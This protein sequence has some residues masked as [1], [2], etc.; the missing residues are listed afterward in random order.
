MTSRIRDE[1]LEPD[2]QLGK[3]SSMGLICFQDPIDTT[4]HLLISPLHTISTETTIGGME[5]LLTSYTLGRFSIYT[6]CKSKS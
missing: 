3:V 5:V 1:K 2:Y 4:S 6:I